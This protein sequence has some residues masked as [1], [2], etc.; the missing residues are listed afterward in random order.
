MHPDEACDGYDAYSI[1]K[2]G[3]DHHG[4]FLPLVMQGFSDY[5]MPLFQYSLVPLVAAFGLK[6]AVVRLG[7]ALWGIVDLVAITFLA[8]LMMGWP[9]AAAAALFGAFS[10]WHLPFSRYGMGAITGSAT[11]T[12]GMLCFFLWLRRHRDAWLLLSGAFFGLSLYSYAITKAFLP[13]LIS[14]LIVLYWRELKAVRLKALAAA[15]IVMLFA[16]P[17]AI[18][19]LMH[20]A[21]MQA[22]FHNLSVFDIIATCRGCDPEQAR[23]TGHS[24]FYQLIGFAA[25]WLSYFTPSFLFLVGDR[26]DH[27][28]M[29]HPPGFG[30]LLPEQAPLILLALAAIV[31]ARRRKTALLLAGWLIVAALPAAFTLPGGGLASGS[32]RA[33]DAERDA[34][35]FGQALAADALL[36]A[37]PSRSAAR[38]AGDG[39]LDSFLRPGICGAARMDFADGGAEGGCGGTDPFGRDIPWRAICPILLSRFSDAGRALLPVWNRTD[40]S[41]G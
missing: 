18:L 10:P 35:H 34:R 3:R 41:R 22:Q 5:R 6:P 28:T 9:A 23:A 31:S 16:L 14:L 30:Q 26:G 15:A 40:S 25:N 7:A 8:G 20:S 36:A 19:L 4:N 21:E 32:A 1:L 17:Q 29:L 33:A 11:V 38:L 13:L 2:T 12:L 27:W 39:A 24:L 37:F